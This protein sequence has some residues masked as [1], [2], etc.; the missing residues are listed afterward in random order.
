MGALLGFNSLFFGLVYSISMPASAHCPGE[1]N[2]RNR[3]AFRLRPDFSWII[4]GPLVFLGIGFFYVELLAP[5]LLFWQHWFLA[6]IIFLLVLLSQLGHALAHLWMAKAIGQEPPLVLKVAFWGDLAQSWSSSGLDWKEAVSAMAG[7]VFQIALGFVCFLLWD[8]QIGPLFN[9][10]TGFG[11]AWNVCMALLNLAPGFPLDGGRLTRCLGVYAGIPVNPSHRLSRWLGRLLVAGLVGWGLALIVQHARFGVETGVVCVGLALLLLWGSR[12]GETDPKDPIESTLTTPTNPIRFTRLRKALAILLVLVLALASAMLLPTTNGLEGPGAALPVEP[13]VV[14]PTEVVHIKAGQFLLT[15]VYSQTPLLLGQYLYGV[16]NPFIQIVPPEHI[17][18]PDTTPQEL[19]QRSITQLDE[20]ELIAQV[21]GLRLAGYSVPLRGEGALVLA[22]SE[23][24]PAQQT[25]QVGDLIR[26][27]DSKPTLTADALVSEIQNHQPGN[28]VILHILRNQ[29]EM[30]VTVLLIG[31][32]EGKAKLGV[33][34][35]TDHLSADFPLPIQLSPQ[36][37]IGGPSAGLMFTITI[38]DLLTSGDL[39]QG[40]IVAGTG[41]IDLEGN[42]GPIGGVRYKVVA[43]E[44]AG[45]TIFLCPTE[46]L[47]D[48][49]VAARSIQ[50]IEVR[51][52]QQAI[53]FLKDGYPGITSP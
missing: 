38:Y 33:S 40:R 29:K 10:A 3:T 11:A 6:L 12:P 19:L 15:S 1:A 21:V 31:S 35:Q 23:G 4:M 32:Q 51:T 16:L 30:T 34:V 14:L 45:A 18:P 2:K 47:A 50:V 52:A 17:V 42:I 27:L 46:N 25:L 44:E 48:A 37:I 22:L 53:D 24:S 7:L 39:K 26:A 28:P 5:N 36:K 13:M 20:S 9:L 8:R 41:T 49:R 43:A